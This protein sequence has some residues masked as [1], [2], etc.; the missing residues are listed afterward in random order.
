MAQRPPATYSLGFMQATQV[1]VAQRSAQRSCPDRL[2]RGVQ[3][4]PPCPSTPSIEVTVY[5]IADP[6]DAIDE[7]NNANNIDEGPDVVC[8]VVVL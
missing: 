5:G 7:C 8:G 1:L 6:D 3:R 2:H 4:L